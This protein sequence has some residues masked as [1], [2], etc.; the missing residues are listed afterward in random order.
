MNEKNRKKTIIIL[1]IVVLALIL[2]FS[3]LLILF[4]GKKI[5][6]NYE[7]N[8]LNYPE[9]RSPPKY[10]ISELNNS[11]NYTVFRVIYQSEKFLDNGGIIYGIIYLPK[12]KPNVPGIVFLPG[13]SIKKENEPAGPAIAN[14]GYAVLVIDQRGI[15]ETGGFYPSFEQDKLIFDGKVESIQH[16]G[17]Y[18]AL[19]AVDVLRNIDSVNKD[20]IM[21]GGASM[22]GRY[23]MI[24]AALD[25]KIN[26]ALIISSA[27]FHV[28][29]T[30]LKDD[31]Y[32][33]SID[34]D[35][36]V[37]NITP[38]K[39]VMIHSL[40]DN[41]IPIGD[42]ALTYTYAHE[43]KAFYTVNNCTHGYCPAMLPFINAELKKI[44]GE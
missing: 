19:R 20:K 28:E 32:Y 34:P 1:S 9:H 16:L 37:S 14:L 10:S 24:A 6:F 18:D 22:G 26:G 23:A 2:F 31:I 15:G 44:M 29:N 11:G 38:A 43:P 21:I 42:A 36:Y 13:G 8:K 30:S 3:A 41:I 27:G 33:L 7:T 12:N 25:H 17:V 39:L 5:Y 40:T 4:G 35:R